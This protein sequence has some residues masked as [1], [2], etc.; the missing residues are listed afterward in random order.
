MRLIEQVGSPRVK[1]LF[2]IYHQQV[3]EGNTIQLV[4]HYHPYV[5]YIHVA[6]VPGRHEPGTGE[7][8]Y[9]K[10]AEALREVGYQGVVGLEAI[11]LADDEQ[12][13]GRFREVFG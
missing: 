7:I 1:I 9:P 5:G 6:D 4:R 2:D 3:E 8:N 11:P 10:V 13:L 12:A